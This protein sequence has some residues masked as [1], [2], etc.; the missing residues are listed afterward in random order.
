MPYGFL[1]DVVVAI[2]VAYVSFVVVGE[3]AILLGAWLGWGWVRNRWFRVAHLLAIAIVA[4]EAIN[5]IE[6]PLTGWEYQ[7]RR[8]AGQDVSGET[9]VGRLLH[10]VLFYEMPAWAFTTMYVGFAV[11]VLGTLVL[12]PPRWRRVSDRSSSDGCAV[13]PPQKAALTP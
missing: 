8:L 1:A 2:H 5:N 6:C 13:P 12:V 7:L 9:F 4:Y 3:L 10:S 11:L